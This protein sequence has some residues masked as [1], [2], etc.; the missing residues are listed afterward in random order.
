MPVKILIPVLTL[1]LALPASVY[2]GKV[3]EVTVR[4]AQESAKKSNKLIAYFFSGELRK[5]GGTDRENKPIAT[6][7]YNTR[8]TEENNALEKVLPRRNVVVINVERGEDMEALPENVRKANAIPGLVITTGDGKVV[9]TMH[10]WQAREETNDK[11][12]ELLEKTDKIIAEMKP[13][14]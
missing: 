14:P 1:S 6:G 12:K 9:V 5:E 8:V 3:S 13:A 2:A 7:S 4:R 10:G 11:K